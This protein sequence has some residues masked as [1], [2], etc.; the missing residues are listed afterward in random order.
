MYA[1]IKTD[2]RHKIDKQGSTVA[3]RTKLGWIIL[4]PGEE[5]DTTHMLLTQTSQMDFEE[6]CRIDV[7][8]FA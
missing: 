1:R 7:F 5:I 4:S 8:G 6:L 2:N 3:E